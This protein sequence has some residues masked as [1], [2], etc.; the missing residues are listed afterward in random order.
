MELKDATRMIL[1][2]SAAHPPLLGYVKQLHGEFAAGREVHYS[3]LLAV[4]KDA[5]RTDALS[6]L[7]ERDPEAYAAIVTAL[8]R[9]IDRQA[10]VTL[11]YVPSGVRQ[12]AATI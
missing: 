5:T 1:M 3:A 4:L 10:P 7:K 6:E 11:P 9:E 12:L 8:A 2:E